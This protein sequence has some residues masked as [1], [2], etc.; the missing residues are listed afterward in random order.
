MTIDQGNIDDLNLY[1]VYGVIIEAGLKTLLQDP[2]LKDPETQEWPEQ[3]GIEVDLTERYYKARTVSLDVAL[4]ADTQDEYFSKY[5][6][7][8]A[9]LRSPGLRQL[10]LKRIDRSFFIYFVKS[11][12]MTLITKFKGGKIGTKFTLE[13]VEPNP[14]LLQKYSY[15][16]DDDSNFLVTDEGFKIIVNI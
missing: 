9:V 10:Y 15:L 16:I 7:L 12:N 2:D 4:I 11:S 6:A 5:T 14:S 13:F 3:N 1:G 8:M